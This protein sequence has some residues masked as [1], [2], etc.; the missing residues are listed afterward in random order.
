MPAAS[1]RSL[2]AATL[3][4]SL[5]TS[6]RQDQGAAISPNVSANAAAANVARAEVPVPPSLDRRTLL[7]AV[8]E[9][10]SAAAGG[11]DD[12][13]QQ[14][15]LDGRR[16]ELRM[17]IGCTLG[18]EA[19]PAPG[20]FASADAETRRVELKAEPGISLEHPI[21]AAMA[22]GRFEAA[23][24]FWVP[25]PWLLESVCPVAATAQPQEAGAPAAAE[26]EPGP[27]VQP[28]PAPQPAVGLAQFFASDESR[29]GRRDG[30]A[31]V[32]RD[33]WAENDPPPQP[34]SWELVITG[35]LRSIDGRAILC[36]AEDPSA[37][38]L[39]IISASFDRVAIE[40]GGRELAEWSRG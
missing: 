13:T 25:Q 27:A 8:A 37:P 28:A 31:Y 40:S 30:R 26:G 7:R 33:E 16:F 18:A 11:A 32:A 23:E 15:A 9:A 29:L 12:R 14:A 4:A 5:A 20:L 22:A 6:C 39:C 24:G 1:T 2:L 36:R 3:I 38:P 19:S 17:R 34:G 35:R 21:A 10:R